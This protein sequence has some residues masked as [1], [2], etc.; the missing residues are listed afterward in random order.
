M[1]KRQLIAAGAAVLTTVTAGIVLAATNSQAEPP[2][3][4]L[5]T[6]S[7]SKQS[8]LDTDAPVYT[9]SA[10]CVENSDGYRLS[11]FGP[12]KFGPGLTG[13]PVSDVG[14][15]TTDPIQVTQGLTFKDIAVDANATIVAGE[16]TAVVYCVDSFEAADRGT[17]TKKF[18]FTDATHWQVRNPADPTTTTTTTTTAP[19]TTTTTTTT[20]PPTTTTTTSTVPPTTTTVPSTTTTTVEP[21]TTTTVAPTTTTTTV[22]PTTTT[23]EPTTTTVEPTTT[24]VEPTTT[25]VAPTTT[26]VEPTSTTTTVAPTSSTTTSSTS[27]T[28]TTNS[29]T[30]SSSTTSSSGST[31]TTTTTTNPVP[32]LLGTL[33]PSKESGIS[34]DAGTFTTEK[35]CVEASDMFLIRITGP[36]DGFK[37][38]LVITTVTDQGYFEDQPIVGTQTLS[39]RDVANDNQATI[40][41]GADY[42]VE[43]H[44]MDSFESKSKGFFAAVVTF[45]N[46]RKDPD[47]AKLLLHDWT[48]KKGALPTTTSGPTTTTTTVAGGSTTTTVPGGGTNPTTNDPTPQG[49]AGSGGLAST[50]ASV[51]L[52]LLAG[53]ALVGFGALALIASR[54]RRAAAAPGEWPTE[55]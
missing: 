45:S 13:A 10:P 29:S 15:S 27:V 37:D 30:T 12:A 41:V 35:G 50:G 46:E 4:T 53:T 23:V 3:A 2:A 17:F 26:T 11:I 16:Y 6:L 5:G 31:T 38:G 21:T 25:T 34:T 32:G 22:E 14:F 19:P 39:F 1:R 52:A 49:S 42:T 9:T 7:F 54:R 18:Y 55:S 24:T 51:G 28:T 48:W 43:L 33:T 47:D 40:V 8:G 44:C 20:V 36:G